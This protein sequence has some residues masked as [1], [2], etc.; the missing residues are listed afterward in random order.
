MFIV[1]TKYLK[2]L[3]EV[4]KFRDAHLAYFRDLAEKNKIVGGG[5]LS[6]ASG[7]IIVVL[8]SDKAELDKILQSDPYNQ[9]GLV[10]CEIFE[11]DIKGLMS[12]RLQEFLKLK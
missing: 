1:K 6:D 12:P 2:P 8:E 10:S 7:A 4:A 3:E 11:F 9:N 5:R